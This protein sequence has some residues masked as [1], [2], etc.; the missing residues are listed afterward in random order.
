MRAWTVTARFLN[1]TFLFTWPYSGIKRCS[2]GVQHAT[3]LAGRHTEIRRRFWYFKRQQTPTV[4]S[5][6]Q[7]EPRK[8]FRRSDPG[9]WRT[10]SIDWKPVSCHLWFGTPF[11]MRWKD[12][13]S[14]FCLGVVVG[15][16]CHWQ[17][18]GTLNVEFLLKNHSNKVHKMRADYPTGENI[19]KQIAVI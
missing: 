1:H 7:V 16:H 9:W 6:P 11:C 17:S 3:D 8:A 4:Y 10:R 5:S 13:K 18:V 14:L 2:W 19:Q 15:S 12:W